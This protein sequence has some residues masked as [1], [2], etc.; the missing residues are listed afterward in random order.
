[1]GKENYRDRWGRKI[2]G[3]DGEGEFAKKIGRFSQLREKR[4][5]WRCL[6]I[7]RYISGTDLEPLSKTAKTQT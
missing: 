2:I 4:L 6:I 1:M 5:N 7:L 3:T